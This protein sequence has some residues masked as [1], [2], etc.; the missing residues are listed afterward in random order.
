M[1]SSPVIVRGFDRSNLRLTV[2]P[3]AD[4]EAKR[5][6]LFIKLS[7]AERPGIICVATRKRAERLGVELAERGEEVAVYHGGMTPAEKTAAEDAFRKDEALVLVTADASSLRLDK[8]DVRFVFHYDVAD[9]LESYCEEIGHA[10]R[11]GRPAEAIL[12]YRRADLHLRR[13]LASGGEVEDQIVQRVLHAIRESPEPHKPR[14]LSTTLDLAVGKVAAAI[15]GLDAVGAVTIQA[16]GEV[17]AGSEV[18]DIE[19]TARQAT[20]AQADFRR[21]E[22]MRS[23][24]MQAYAEIDFCRR[25]YLLN[26][27]GEPSHG[28]CRNCDNDLVEPNMFD[29]TPVELPIDPLRPFP[30]KSWV[31]HPQWGRGLVIRY[32][33]NKI[34]ILFEEVGY[35]TFLLQMVLDKGLLKPLT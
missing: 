22:M 9:S 7:R 18:A 33:H 6:A 27:F 21:L 29:I 12:F 2:L 24:M 8:P 14:E 4:E 30:M 1:R 16:T 32:E 11:D 5:K 31:V 26:Y 34:E 23:E 28:P 10:G 20:L 35:K 3:C 15:H 17:A 19:E 25:Q 13:L